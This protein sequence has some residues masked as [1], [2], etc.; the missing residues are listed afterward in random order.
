MIA[1]FDYA[2]INSISK[3]KVWYYTKSNGKP[4]FVNI[5]FQQKV[6][7][8]EFE[9][10]NNILKLDNVQNIELSENQIVTFTTKDVR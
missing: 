5:A 9:E 1:P 6:T 4:F 7:N 8:Q 2:S 3:I 10:I